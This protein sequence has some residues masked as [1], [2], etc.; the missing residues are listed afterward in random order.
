MFEPFDRD[1][2]LAAN[3]ID[4]SAFVHRRRLV[5]QFG[6][7][8]EELSRLTDWDLILRYTAHAPAYPLPALAVRYRVL[9][10]KRVSATE[11]PEPD[12]VRIRAKWS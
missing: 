9:D 8:D 1:R 7:F 6:G 3:Y 10:E 11:N 12:A 4:M 2:L 5:D